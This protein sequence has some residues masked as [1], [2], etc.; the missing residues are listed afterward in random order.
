MVQTAEVG[1]PWSPRPVLTACQVGPTRDTAFLEG[2]SAAH[3]S[4]A[5][6][7]ASGTELL[8]QGPARSC[9]PLC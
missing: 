3:G 9:P 1:A 4:P 6:V 2:A 8:T 5:G 7:G